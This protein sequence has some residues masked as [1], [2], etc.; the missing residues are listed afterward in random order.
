L[1]AVDL[2]VMVAEGLDRCPPDLDVVIMMILAIW[3]TAGGFD[4]VI[5][6]GSAGLFR[7]AGDIP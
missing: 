4:S 6:A 3:R 1:I 7:S 5:P 2:A